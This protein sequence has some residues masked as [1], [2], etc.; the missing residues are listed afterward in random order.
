VRAVVQRVGSASV[1]VGGDPIATIGP[2][3]CV[4]VG[5]GHDDDTASVAKLAD[6][7]WNLRVFDDDRGLMNRSVSETG[8]DVLVVSQFTLYAD[9]S[10]GRRPSFSA[11]APPEIAEPLVVRL[12]EELR[13]RGAKVTSGRFGADMDVRLSNDGPVTV[14]LET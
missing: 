3:L 9:T 5:V 8:R 7:L 6:K 11:A 4:F 2:G 10:R 12:V 1:L 14:I 13:R